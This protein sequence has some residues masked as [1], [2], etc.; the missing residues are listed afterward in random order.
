MTTRLKIRVKELKDHRVTEI[1]K[2]RGISQDCIPYIPE[3]QDQYLNWEAD[4]ALTAQEFWVLVYFDGREMVPEII[5][6]DECADEEISEW[7]LGIDNPAYA[8][9]LEWKDDT[10]LVSPKGYKPIN[11]RNSPLSHREQIEG[12][13]KY[14]KNQKLNGLERQLGMSLA[15]AFLKNL[16]DHANQMVDADERELWKVI[17]LAYQAGKQVERRDAEPSHEI[18]KRSIPLYR[19]LVSKT[20]SSRAP[21]TKHVEKLLLDNPKISSRE[22]AE[23]LKEVHLCDYGVWREDEI[24]IYSDSAKEGYHSKSCATFESAVSRVR[25][26]LEAAR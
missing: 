23:S 10:E 20:R 7:F 15:T 24:T 4:T 16:V 3:T 12:A 25:R 1:K 5:P 26:R 14:Y 11:N 22:I 2:V 8:D 9:Y 18:S 13:M 21:W 17:W 19:N 6:P